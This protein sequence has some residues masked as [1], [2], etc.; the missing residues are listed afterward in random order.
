MSRAR[1][2]QWLDSSG[3]AAQC[4]SGGCYV[5][6]LPGHADLGPRSRFRHLHFAGD[7]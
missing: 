1:G 6:G 3:V 4:Q 7:R 5:L 2:S